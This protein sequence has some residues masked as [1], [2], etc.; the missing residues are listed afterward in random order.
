MITRSRS[1]KD[2]KKKEHKSNYRLK[3]ENENLYGMH[4]ATKNLRHKPR[5][6]KKKH[7]LTICDFNIRVQ[8]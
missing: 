5:I 4:E 6:K 1:V 2:V 3:T 8:E 7:F